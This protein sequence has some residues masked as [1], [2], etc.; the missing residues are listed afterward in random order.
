ML[1]VPS[2]PSISAVTA[3]YPFDR[4]EDAAE[5]ESCIVNTGEIV[6]GI[7]SGSGSESEVESD[8]VEKELVIEIEIE[9]WVVE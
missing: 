7:G 8:C 3:R 5:K 9:M 2:S 6:S 4:L 1:F